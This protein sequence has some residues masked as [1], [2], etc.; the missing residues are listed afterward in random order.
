MSLAL[1]LGLLF[2][3]LDPREVLLLCSFEL[4]LVLTLFG[5]CLFK[6]FTELGFEACI[7][8][9]DVLVTLIQ[10]LDGFFK[11]R[12]ELLDLPFQVQ[13]LFVDI[14]VFTLHWFYLSKNLCVILKLRS[15]NLNIRFLLAQQA[16]LKHLRHSIEIALSRIGSR[17]PMTC[18]KP[19]SNLILLYSMKHIFN[20]L[21][22]Q[23][24]NPFV[25]VSFWCLRPSRFLFW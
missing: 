20:T 3:L 6:L 7:A 11:L 13:I 2:S 18:L 14:S 25:Y 17:C 22:L 4:C 15:Q 16:V 10:S 1:V 12:L 5:L 9:E 19:L 23:M 8:F 24:Q 21:F